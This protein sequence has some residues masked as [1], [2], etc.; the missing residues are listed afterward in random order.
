M[1]Y[2]WVEY[3]DDIWKVRRDL[4]YIVGVEIFFMG[5]L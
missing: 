2:L 5:I 4:D 1:D 3:G